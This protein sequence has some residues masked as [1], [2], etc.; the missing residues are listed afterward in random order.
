[1]SKR[2]YTV[3]EAARELGLT[4]QGLHSAIRQMVKAGL[5]QAPVLEQTELVGSGS[6]MRL[7]IK[8]IEALRNRPLKRK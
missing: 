3:R 4:R 8:D 7:T 5:M 1:M 6:V 2:T